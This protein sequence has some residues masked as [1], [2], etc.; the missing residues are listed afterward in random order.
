VSSR[1]SEFARVCLLYS[2]LVNNGVQANKKY[3]RYAAPLWVWLEILR[4]YML[5]AN[6]IKLYKYFIF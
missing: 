5:A 3:F 2:L 4:L 6:K 1:V